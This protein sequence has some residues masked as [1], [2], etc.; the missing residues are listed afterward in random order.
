MTSKK[1]IMIYGLVMTA[2]LVIGSVL[3]AGIAVITTPKALQ[4]LNRP[5]FIKPF[6][7]R[8][9]TERGVYI[10]GEDIHINISFMNDG[11]QN[12]TLSDTLYTVTIYG[13]NG[14]VFSFNGGGIFCHAQEIL[15]GDSCWIGSSTW[16]QTDT[17]H[18]QVPAGE[19]TIDVTFIHANY[20]GETTVVIGN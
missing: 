8:V 6:M 13:P 15:P 18:Q 5:T 4:E 16:N 19:Y 9:I 1:K 2:V 20:H 10:P 17:N 14:S 3:G 7:V 11:L 12:I